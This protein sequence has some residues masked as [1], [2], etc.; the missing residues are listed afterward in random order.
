MTGNRTDK[1]ITARS[2]SRT[3]GANLG[4]VTAVRP[5]PNVI[6]RELYH[7]DWPTSR[8]KGLSLL[9]WSSPLHW[10]DQSADAT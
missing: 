2:G 9:H 6:G 5:P 3:E 1:A 8:T 7:R 4:R 10:S